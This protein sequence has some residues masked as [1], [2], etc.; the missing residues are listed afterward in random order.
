MEQQEILV[1]LHPYV[2]SEYAKNEE[3]VFEI[4]VKGNR[5]FHSIDCTGCKLARRCGCI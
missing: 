1:L 5:K 2:K 4:T 3:G